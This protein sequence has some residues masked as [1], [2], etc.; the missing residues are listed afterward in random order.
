[1]RITPFDCGMVIR[2]YGSGNQEKR[3]FLLRMIGHVSGHFCDHL[4]RFGGAD[5]VQIP[6]Y[7]LNSCVLSVDELYTSFKSGDC[8]KRKVNTKQQVMELAQELL[9]K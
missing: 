3:K 9:I 8:M 6:L 1:M 7:L 2:I 4:V 5:S